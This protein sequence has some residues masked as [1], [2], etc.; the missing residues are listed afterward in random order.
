MPAHSILPSRFAP[1][2]LRRRWVRRRSGLPAT[3]RIFGLGLTRTG[4]SS[5]T[6]ALNLLGYRSLHLPQDD[7]TK[8]EVKA[9]LAGGGDRL[10][11]SV[12]KKYDALTDTPICAAFEG[13]DAAYP[14]SRFVLTVREKESWLESC[15]RFFW[16]WIDP[17]LLANP[18]N[19]SVDY[20]RAIHRKIYGT[21]TFDR[22]QFSRAHDEYHE[23]V[24]RHFRD[25]SEDLLTI[26]ICAGEGW[27]PLCEFLALPHPGT[28]FPYEEPMFFVPRPRHAEPVPGS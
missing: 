9:F 27:D 19:P 4:T 13:L 1:S 6:R 12:L 15:Q 5:L 3:A 18:D 16:D 14:G 11:L 28:Q 21:P 7:R 20:I 25:R 22:E 2:S 17:W 24:R 8:D 26:D 10:R 23:R